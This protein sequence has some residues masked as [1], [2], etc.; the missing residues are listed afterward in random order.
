M[1][2]VVPPSQNGNG[3]DPVDAVESHPGAGSHRAPKRSRSLLR[4]LP[5]SATLG[6]A[7]LAIAG[8]GVVHQSSAPTEETIAAE[9]ASLA[10]PMAAPDETRARLNSPEVSRSISRA[11]LE[12]QAETQAEQRKQALRQLASKSEDHSAELIKK[13]KARERREAQKEKKE[14]AENESSDGLAAG[15]EN[16]DGGDVGAGQ[17]SSRLPAT[18]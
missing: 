7:T 18:A 11:T 13:K 4:R 6:V 15:A 8:V 16:P 1:S 2:P 10:G 5:F 9:P 14:A 12:K 3:G 17:W